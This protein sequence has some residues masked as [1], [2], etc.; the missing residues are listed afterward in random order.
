MGNALDAATF[1]EK[2]GGADTFV[3]LVGVAH[4]SPAKAKDFREIDFKSCQESVAAAIVNRV[5]HFI[6]VSVAHPAPV[7]KAYIEVRTA[8]EEMIRASG[9]NATILRPWYVLG[10]GHYWAYLLKPGYW[11]ARQI[12]SQQFNWQ[13]SRMQLGHMTTPFA[14][15]QPWQKKQTSGIACE[16]LPPALPG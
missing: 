8:C 6:Y 10:P 2:I 14:T 12:P 13:F 1:R 3:Q 16:L 4:P 5:E 9:L 15:P 11:L 7:M